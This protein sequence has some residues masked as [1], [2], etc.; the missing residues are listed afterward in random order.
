MISNGARKLVSSLAMLQRLISFM[1]MVCCEKSSN[2]RFLLAI[3]F[4]KERFSRM[5]ME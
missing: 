5:G 4:M 3:F 1:V 2:V